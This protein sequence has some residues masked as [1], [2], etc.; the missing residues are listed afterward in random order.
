MFLRNFGRLSEECIVFIPEDRTLHKHRCEYLKSCKH[1]GGIM[2]VIELLYLLRVRNNLSENE[3]DVR[4]KIM[5]ENFVIY[6]FS[7]YSQS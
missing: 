7:L 1:R 3:L 4:R 2:I 5:E 6:I